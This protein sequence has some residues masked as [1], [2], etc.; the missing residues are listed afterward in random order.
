MR[1]KKKYIFIPVLIV[2]GFH[3][4]S[5]G[6][7]SLAVP[8]EIVS[9]KAFLS[10]D[11]IHPGESFYFALKCDISDGW[12]INADVVESEFQIPTEVV[13]DT[14][15]GISFGEQKFPE[16]ER[17]KFKFSDDKIPIFSEEI[18]I[19]SSVSLASDF[20]TGETY[21]SG[22]LHYQACNDRMCLPPDD[23]KWQVGLNITEKWIE[24]REINREIFSNIAFPSDEISGEDSWDIADWMNRR[25]LFITFLLVFIG[26]LALNLTPCVYPLIPI[27]IS[28]FGSQSTGKIS[29]SLLLALFY[30]L[31]M[32]LTYSILGT[33]AAATGSMFGSALQ[34]PLVLIVIALI[35]IGLSLSMF[36]LYEIRVPQSLTKLGGKSRSGILGSLFMGL[37]VGIIAAPCIGPFVLSLLIF[38]GEKGN[39]FL[40]FWL[41]FTLAL[42]LG[43]PFLILG[44]FSGMVSSLPQSGTWMVWVR[45]LFG[46]ILIGMAL[47]FIQ[48]LLSEQMY[49]ILLVLL[50]IGGGLYLGWLEKSSGGKVFRTIRW[51]I[52]GIILLLGIWFALP[53]EQSVGI[54]WHSFKYS[55]LDQ[56]KTERKPVF[57]DFYADWCIPCK[58]LD[59]KTFSDKTV[60]EESKRFV[61]L[62][63]NTTQRSDFVKGVENKFHI[64]GVPT[65]L[66]FNRNGDEIEELRFFGFIGPD[67]F[68]AKMKKVD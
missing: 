3:S 53:K 40:G 37:T 36:G 54:E 42:G 8:E 34:N 45:K 30:V 19:I 26:G 65:V 41:F 46:I 23:V 61:S 44:T 33:I 4:L 38:V 48:T 28:Y 59:H 14:I 68:L 27:T 9:V 47:Y 64:R 62:K 49:R 11:G 18:T 67:E 57:I 29:K 50:L 6:Q 60:V 17:K 13:F 12:H 56:A 52:G 55:L 58:E 63:M 31:G 66:F 20:P 22:K 25:G 15:A 24:G 51:G 5:L 1:I 7:V 21:V 10:R 39:P 32:A 2:L 16:V 35:L 43:L